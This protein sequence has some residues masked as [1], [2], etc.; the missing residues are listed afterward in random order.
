MEPD[1]DYMGMQSNYFTDESLIRFVTEPFLILPES[2]RMG[3]RIAGPKIEHQNGHDIVSDGIV[4]GA[5]QVPGTGNPIVLLADHQTTGGYPKISTVISAVLSNGQCL[6]PPNPTWRVEEPRKI[7]Q[8][9][10]GD[11]NNP[12]PRASL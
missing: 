5:I 11:P 9:E 4:T 10:P 8:R 1:P 7:T 2:D 6:N 3:Y 12:E